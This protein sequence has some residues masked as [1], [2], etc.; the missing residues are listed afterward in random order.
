MATRPWPVVN[1]VRVAV[2]GLTPGGV[3]WAN[4][5]WLLTTAP[6]TPA[7][8]DCDALAAAVY[9]KYQARILPLLGSDLVLKAAVANFYGSQPTQVVGA[10]LE[11]DNGGSANPVEV[12]SLSAVIS[13]IFPATWRGGKPRT[14]VPG[15]PS[16][17]F[18]SSN[19]LDPTFISA[20]ETA[21]SNFRTDVAAISVSP[22]SGAHLGVMSF[23]SGNAP[24][25]PAVAFNITGATVHPR[26]C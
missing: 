6:S 20:L 7:P 24:R 26:I 11:D 8:S 2:E 4:I 9:A 5:F 25:I 15:L 17:A 22:F 23:F 19:R 12:D 21:A 3:N 13:W 1:S 14:Y 16:E 18:T 10:H